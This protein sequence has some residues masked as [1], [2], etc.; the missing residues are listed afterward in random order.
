MVNTAVNG[1]LP[2]AVGNPN[3][4]LAKNIFDYERN[5]ETPPG[6]IQGCSLQDTCGCKNG[7]LCV[8]VCCVCTHSAGGKQGLLE[9]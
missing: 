9:E 1:K 7:G 4:H 3:Q 2:L 5:L 8:K 6:V